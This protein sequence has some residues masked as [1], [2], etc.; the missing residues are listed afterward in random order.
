MEPKSEIKGCDNAMYNFPWVI[1]D[2]GEKRNKSKSRQENGL[3]RLAIVIKVSGV[4][5]SV[6]RCLPLTSQDL[7][8]HVH[9]AGYLLWVS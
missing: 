5:A 4:R 6:F 1:V 2:D 7:C 8:H 9:Q 3:A